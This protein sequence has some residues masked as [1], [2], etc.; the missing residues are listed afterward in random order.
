MAGKN[1]IRLLASGIY[2]GYIPGVPGTYGSILAL[3]L[4][5][6]YPGSIGTGLI[7]LLFGVGIIITGLEEKNCGIKDDSRIVF[8]EITGLFVAVAYLDKTI[9]IFILAFI[10]F[11]FFDIVKPYPI[12]KLQK[13]HGGIGI[14]FDDIAA[15]LIT[16][17]ILQLIFKPWI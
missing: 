14:M 17:I 6:L 10:L 16:N 5:Y 2:T 8:D 15:G 11:R 1:I 13:F 7:L 9:A 4:A 3:G 12:N